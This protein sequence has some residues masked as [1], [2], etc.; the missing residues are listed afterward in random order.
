ME[1][2]N[3][4]VNSRNDNA[5]LDTSLASIHRDFVA[6]P[7]QWEYFRFLFFSSHWGPSA[8]EGGVSRTPLIGGR[9]KPKALYRGPRFIL[10]PHG[11]LSEAEGFV[12]KPPS[13]PS[14]ANGGVLRTLVSRVIIQS[15]GSSS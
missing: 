3:N 12:S 13:R 9:V 8:A 4:G 5:G 10:H 15:S 11:G 6:P 1:L 2:F 7:G 14:A